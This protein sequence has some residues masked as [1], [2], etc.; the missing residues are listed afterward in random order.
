MRELATWQRI[1]SVGSPTSRCWPA[2]IQAAGKLREMGK[3]KAVKVLKQALKE[4]DHEEIFILCRMLFTAKPKGAFHAPAFGLPLGVGH[5]NG[6]DWTLRPIEIV[7]GV[8]VPGHLGLRYHR[9]SGI[10]GTLPCYYC[11]KRECDWGNGAEF[12]PR[13]EEQMKKA[14]EKLLA[15]KKWKQPLTAMEME[16]LA[17]QIK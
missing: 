16:F 2:Y 5:T 17:A 8:P 14:P 1:W 7:D 11:L 13:T 10:G 15:S 9:P 4:G 3:E 6:E 12:K